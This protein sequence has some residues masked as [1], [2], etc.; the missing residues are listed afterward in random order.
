MK[1]Y[2]IAWVEYHSRIVEVE[3]EEEAYEE[4]GESTDTSIISWET[5]ELREI[6]NPE[7]EKLK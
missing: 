1:T 7:E 4:V 2:K 5:T 3:D 6:L